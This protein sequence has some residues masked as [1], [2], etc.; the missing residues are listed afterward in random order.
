MD[1]SQKN[2]SVIT[3]NLQSLSDGIGEMNSNI[4]KLRKLNHQMDSYNS[5]AC[6]Y[7][8]SVEKVTRMLDKKKTPDNF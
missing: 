6:L 7:L 8:V 4:K 2:P 3:S 5:S 1:Y